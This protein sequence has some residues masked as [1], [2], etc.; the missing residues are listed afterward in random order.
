MLL[1]SQFDFRPERGNKGWFWYK[2][3][4]GRLYCR[5]YWANALKTYF[6]NVFFFCLVVAGFFF[7]FSLFVLTILFSAYLTSGFIHSVL[8]FCF[9]CYT[10]MR[11]SCAVFLQTAHCYIHAAALVAEYLKRQGN[12]HKI[13]ETK[14]LHDHFFLH[15]VSLSGLLSTMLFVQVQVILTLSQTSSFICPFDL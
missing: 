8:L 12:T 2:Q 9:C 11:M 6:W 1:L 4:K 3:C 13:T 14:F 7:F 10:L 15:V 5:P